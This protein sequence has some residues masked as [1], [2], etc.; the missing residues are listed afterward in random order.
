M[1]GWI[2]SSGPGYRTGGGGTGGG[3]SSRDEE[4]RCV[5]YDKVI[6]VI[7]DVGGGVR[8]YI[9]LS[10]FDT[11]GENCFN[12]VG[13]MD[14][15]KLEQHIRSLHVTNNPAQRVSIFYIH[16][17]DDDDNGEFREIVKDYQWEARWR[18]CSMS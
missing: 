1:A 8:D 17:S 9:K 3:G 10:R 18:A 11:S 12:N 2:D 6:C 14:L 15:S 13:Q 16:P 5:D 7:R 4:R